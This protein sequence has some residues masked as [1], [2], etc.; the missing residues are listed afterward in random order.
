MLLKSAVK[1]AISI[2]VKHNQ[3]LDFQL[4]PAAK[5]KKKKFL[6]AIGYVTSLFIFSYGIIIFGIYPE[7]LRNHISTK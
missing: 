2:Y 1:Q 5:Q 3:K 6:K 7:F 4:L